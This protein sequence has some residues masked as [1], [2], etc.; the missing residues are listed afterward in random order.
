M[1]LQ[2]NFVLISTTEHLSEINGV[3][4]DNSFHIER[5]TPSIC[6]LEAIGKIKGFRECLYADKFT[7]DNPEFF[8]G[9]KLL[10]EWQHIDYA[11]KN[12]TMQYQ[13]KLLVPY[14]GIIAR[15]NKKIEAVNGNVIFHSVEKDKIYTKGYEAIRRTYAQAKVE[16]VSNVK[17]YW[18]TELDGSSTEH[19]CEPITGDVIFFDYTKSMS[20]EDEGYVTLDREY[21]FIK[22]FNIMMSCSEC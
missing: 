1:T 21:R 14:D 7:C 2:N 10:V 6:T 16:S 12:P 13:G 19:K 3:L 20:I 17:S 8:V 11:L 15:I 4:I 18:L 5:A 9:D 22:S